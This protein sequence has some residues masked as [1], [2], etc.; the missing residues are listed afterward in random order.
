MN[1]NAWGKGGLRLK[2]DDTCNVAA[3]SAHSA[4]VTV[5]KVRS[6]LEETLKLRKF[7]KIFSGSPLMV[8]DWSVCMRFSVYS[9]YCITS[10][11]P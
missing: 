1:G 10:Y 4:L 9:T 6:F 5:V 3:A 11:M 8:A 2:F 7:Q